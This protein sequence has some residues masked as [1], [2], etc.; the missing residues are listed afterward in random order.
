MVLEKECKAFLKLLLK[1]LK[2]CNMVLVIHC[3]GFKFE[4]KGKL[5]QEI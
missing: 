5:L 1:L 3:M 2:E 4:K